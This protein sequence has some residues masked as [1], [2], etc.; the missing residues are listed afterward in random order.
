MI[1]F[2]PSNPFVKMYAFCIENY[3]P[4]PDK[5]DSNGDKENKPV[6]EKDD[7]SNIQNN[8]SIKKNDSDDNMKNNSVNK[9]ENSDDNIKNKA[10]I[11]KNDKRNKKKN[12]ATKKDNSNNNINSKSFYNGNPLGLQKADLSKEDEGERLFENVPIKLTKSSVSQKFARWLTS[13]RS[14]W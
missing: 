9:K 10:V 3:N 6:I 13:G 14:L 4:S 2:T 7:K 12:S 8:P 5:N 11:K 1:Y